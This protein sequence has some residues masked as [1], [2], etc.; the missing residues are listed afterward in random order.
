MEQMLNDY[1]QCREQVMK[2]IREL[3]RQIGQPYLRTIE[4]ESLIVRRDLLKTES[5]ELLH[6]IHELKEYVELGKGRVQDG[7]SRGDRHG[8]QRVV[9]QRT[10][11]KT[12]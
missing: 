6:V 9:H 3:N 12:G 7:E 11:R 5:Q 4:R 10:L 8:V 1:V 2:R